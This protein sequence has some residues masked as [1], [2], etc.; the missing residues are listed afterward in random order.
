MKKVIKPSAVMIFN[1]NGS[2]EMYAAALEEMKFPP[3]DKVGKK[4][5]DVSKLRIG[6]GGAKATIVEKPK[7]LLPE[8]KFEGTPFPF[9]VSCLLEFAG[10]VF[11]LMTFAIPIA[12]GAAMMSWVMTLP[13]GAW[14]TYN[15]A[16][17]LPN[18]ILLY[19]AEV[20]AL[21]WLIVGEY[22][23]AAY[24][25]GSKEYLRWWLF[26]RIVELWET[27]AAVWLTETILLNFIYKMM[28][29]K[30]DMGANM[31]SFIREFDLVE[32]KCG[33]D[34]SGALVTRL[35]TPQGVIMH[36]V[37]LGEAATVESKAVVTPNSSLAD[38]ARL[39]KGIVLEAGTVH[40]PEGKKEECA[41]GEVHMQALNQLTNTLAGPV[42]I[43]MFLGPMTMTKVNHLNSAMQPLFASLGNEALAS[44][45]SN[46][47]WYFSYIFGIG[48]LITLLM[49]PAKWLLFGRL[50]DGYVASGKW[51]DW[52]VYLMTFWQKLSYSLFVS[53]W[54]EGTLMVTW[55]YNAFGASISMLS[56][57]RFY[58]LFN[59]WHADFIT[60]EKGTF[61]SN[62]LMHPGTIDDHK[63]LK[64]IHLRE[65]AF[66]GLQS[67]VYGGC[68]LAPQSTVATLSRCTDSLA[69]GEQVI[70]ET[71]RQGSVMKATDSELSTLG[72]GYLV[73]SFFFDMGIRALVVGAFIAA[74]SVC[75]RSG[76]PN[77]DM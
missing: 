44:A 51:W 47:C 60:A 49:I 45:A 73:Y 27:W 38:G 7:V 9:E 14:K 67:I 4:N 20:V 29:A 39:K 22:K 1:A 58:G 32:M 42:T 62:A 16:M 55:F 24:A 34:N 48:A 52:R 74:V 3:A 75:T 25:R 46:T 50:R 65:G 19:C 71:R 77:S 21:K 72:Y 33:S 40:E 69:S 8:P 15:N 6:G 13:D 64:S 26:D 63:I 10:T 30:V 37:S 5:F 28:G 56:A 18:V 59:P 53:W 76:P 41:G 57:I 17:V 31:A 11:T 36:R 54:V 43:G 2:V 35:V 70:G 23:P 12:I 61:V 66:V 68:D